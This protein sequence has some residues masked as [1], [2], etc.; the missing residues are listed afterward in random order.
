MK[1]GFAYRTACATH[2]SSLLA[3]TTRQT[4]VV[5][6]C[7]AWRS[8][9][10][11]HELTRLRQEA[12]SQNRHRPVLTELHRALAC[13]CLKALLTRWRLLRGNR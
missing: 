2:Q 4:A 10:R 6:Q 12:C 11:V 5:I 1:Q 13:H 8:K 3:E 9:V 7:C